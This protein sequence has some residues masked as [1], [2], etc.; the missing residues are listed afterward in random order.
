MDSSLP[1]GTR[2]TSSQVPGASRLL[3]SP[4]NVPDTETPGRLSAVGTTAEHVESV[5]LRF[6][7]FCTGQLVH[8]ARKRALEIR[9]GCDVYDSAAINANKV[10][11][12]LGQVIG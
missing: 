1:G 10:M 8:G 7:A 5:T 12:M 2:R 6:E 11:V 4:L 3:V 9:R